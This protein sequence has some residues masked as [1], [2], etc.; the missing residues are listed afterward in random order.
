MCVVFLPCACSAAIIKF[1]EFHG[2]VDGIGKSPDRFFFS[3][4]AEKEKKIGLGTRLGMN[5][6]QY[7]DLKAFSLLLN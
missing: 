2:D 5:L 7:T 1:L 4:T 3:P 6:V